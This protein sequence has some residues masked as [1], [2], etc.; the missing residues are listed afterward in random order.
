MW[1]LRYVIWWERYFLLHGHRNQWSV[2]S[3]IIPLLFSLLLSVLPSQILLICCR[4]EVSWWLKARNIGWKNMILTDGQRSS[5]CS[6]VSVSVFT[7]GNK[8]MNRLTPWSRVPLEKLIIPHI[9]GK[10]RHFVERW[11][12]YTPSPCFMPSFTPFCRNALC[13]FTLHCNLWLWCS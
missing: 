5:L 1:V 6:I 11:L 10:H 9:V 4:A 2:L 13:H 12:S 7:V 8:W 3:T